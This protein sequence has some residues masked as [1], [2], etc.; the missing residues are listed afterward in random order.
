MLLKGGI[1]KTEH[2]P[3]TRLTSLASAGHQSCL[4]LSCHQKTS[5]LSYSSGEHYV[6]T[7][8]DSPNCP[9]QMFYVRQ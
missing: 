9:F 3:V 8:V 4:G 6:F 2:V 5:S 1:N 7:T